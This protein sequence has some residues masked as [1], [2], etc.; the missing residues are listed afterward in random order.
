MNFSTNSC[1]KGLNYGLPCSF[2]GALIALAGID[3]V[4]ILVNGPSACTGLAAAIIEGCRPLMPRN[5]EMF[6]RLATRGHPRI[7]CSEITDTDV[8]LGIGDK[9]IQAIEKLAS[10]RDCEC[11][12]IVNSCSISLIGEDAANILKDHSLSERILYLESTGC[13][14]ALSKGFSDAMIQLIK[15]NAD[16]RVV[17]NGSTINILGLSINQYS[18]KHDV[19]EIQRLMTLAGLKVNTVVAAGSTLE[20]IRNLPNASLNVVIN[21]DYGLEIAR[22]MEE[23]FKIPYVAAERMPI[24]FDATRQLID[25][26]V[27]FFGIPGSSSL[28][29]EELSCRKEAVLALSHSQKTDLMRG[30][31]VAIFGERAFVAG[32]SLFLKDYLGCYPVVLGVEGEH[33][34]NPEDVNSLCSGAAEQIKILTN[35]DQDEVQTALKESRPAIVFGSAF[36]DYMLAQL[37]YS[38][39]FFIETTS[40]VLDRVSL[41]HRPYLGF[42]GALTFV[43]AILNCRLTN[44]YPYS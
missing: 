35:V 33:E 21:P 5:S 24:G 10:K 32:L 44:R 3:G 37:E 25:N 29:E 9:L 42:T 34:L 4:D 1:S 41:V 36:E 38:P 11:I 17:S 40:P 39:K 15:K 16:Q 31:P 30:L 12:A 20:Q 23:R 13:T 7:P 8:I 2:T 28:N 18:W 43:E 26:V 22:F 27:N 14:G 6:S 19:R